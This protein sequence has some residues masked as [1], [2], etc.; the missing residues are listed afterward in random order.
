MDKIVFENPYFKVKVRN[1]I[2]SLTNLKG[3]VVVL[4][5]TEDH[6]VLMVKVY[7]PAIDKTV[8]ELPRGFKEQGETSEESAKREL[9]EETNISSTELISLGSIY[10]DSGLVNSEV[11]LFIAKDIKMDHIILQEI[12]GLKEYEVIDY[13]TVLNLAL[14]GKIKDSFTLCALF[15]SQ[16]FIKDLSL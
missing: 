4:P 12:E 14:N 16:K 7:R 10:P 1:H 13:S 3:G 8:L 15:R 2:L 11:D 5:I 6:K 9:L